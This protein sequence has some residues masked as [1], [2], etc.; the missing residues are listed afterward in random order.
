MY[1]GRARLG[2]L[3]VNADQTGFR[4]LERLFVDHDPCRRTE[5]LQIVNWHSDPES[6]PGLLGIIWALGK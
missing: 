6:F 5:Q 2:I 3:Y 1:Q 4:P